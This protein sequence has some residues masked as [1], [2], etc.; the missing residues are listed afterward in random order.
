MVHQFKIQ[1]GLAEP[2]SP[3][4]QYRGVTAQGV[5]SRVEPTGRVAYDHVQVLL[6]IALTEPSGEQIKLAKHI[7]LPQKLM[8]TIGKSCASWAV[9]VEGVMTLVCHAPP[10]KTRTPSR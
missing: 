10:T 1:R 4:L 3:E 9:V 8:S 6:E 7:Y 2:G 5:I